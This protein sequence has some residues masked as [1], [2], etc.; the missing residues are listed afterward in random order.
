VVW[1]PS[2]SGEKRRRRALR[3]ITVAFVTLGVYLLVQST[4]V[5]VASYHPHHS[6]L[7]IAWTAATAVVMF[8]LAVGKARTGAL[9]GNPVLQAEGRVT[10][11]D[12]VLATAVLLALVHNAGFGWWWADPAAGY[13]LVFYPVREARTA[14]TSTATPPGANP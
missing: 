3:L 14:A 11:I 1:E 12:A 8:A 2:G 13:V 6:R 7:G 4:V 10:R 9:L 5:L